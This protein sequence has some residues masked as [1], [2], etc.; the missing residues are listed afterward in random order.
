[1]SD[2]SFNLENLLD[3]LEEISKVS[4][5]ENTYEVYGTQYTLGILSSDERAK[6]HEYCSKCTNNLAYAI[7]YQIEVLAYT[8]KAINGNYFGNVEFIPTGRYDEN[9]KPIKESRVTFM[10]KQIGKWTE[11][12]RNQLFSHYNELDKEFNRA[13]DKAF[14]F[15]EDDQLVEAPKPEQP[16]E[17]EEQEQKKRPEL[18]RVKEEEQ[19]PQH[20]ESSFGIPEDPHNIPLY[21]ANGNPT[22]EAKH[23]HKMLQS[24]GLASEDQPEQSQT[25]EQLN[26]AQ[27]ESSVSEENDDGLSDDEIRQQLE[28]QYV[29]ASQQQPQS[30]QQA[31]EVYN[32]IT[33]S[34]PKPKPDTQPFQS[35]EPDKNLK[36]SESVKNQIERFRT[37]GE[38]R[39]RS[40]G[41]DEIQMTSRS[42]PLDE[43]ASPPGKVRKVNKRGR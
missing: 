19:Q 36:P 30:P 23:L 20:V 11:S 15:L 26:Q 29:K 24:Q 27:E 8:I 9:D 4:Y 7:T 2:F 32:N 1:M 33:K 18:K 40:V 34:R 38:R 37:Q 13:L 5:T 42:Q 41:E 22:V 14:T 39:D 43:G 3:S 10:R 25:Q 17:K 12:L 35:R 6:I 28:A 31:A 16:R 21:D